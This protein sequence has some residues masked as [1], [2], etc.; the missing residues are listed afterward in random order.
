MRLLLAIHHTT[1][2]GAYSTKLLPSLGPAH[3][4]ACMRV[5]ATGA[6]VVILALVL[7]L[8]LSVDDARAQTFIDVQT[9]DWFYGPVEALASQGAMHGGLDGSFR[10]YA[11]ATRAE[12]AYAIAALYEVGIVQGNADGVFLP[13]ADLERQQAATLVSVHR[14]GVRDPGHPGLE[15]R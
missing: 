9:T 15:M 13:D 10:P 14:S 12:F 3:A 11:P 7:L 4:R 6:A 2:H 1:R 5:V 8:A